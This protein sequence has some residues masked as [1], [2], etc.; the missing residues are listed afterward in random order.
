MTRWLLSENE[1]AAGAEA[2]SALRLYFLGSQPH[3]SESC[4]STEPTV[5]CP[6]VPTYL[7]SFLQESDDNGGVAAPHCPVEWAHPAV[8][9]VLDHGPMVHQKLN[10]QRETQQSVLLPGET[11]RALQGCTTT[12]GLLCSAAWAQTTSLGSDST[13]GSC[14]VLCRSA[15]IYGGPGLYMLISTPSQAVLF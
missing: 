13:S 8:V 6:L 11:L 9:D 1:A 7:C 14:F 3:C 15:W 4:L 12:K 2:A 5:D 10:L